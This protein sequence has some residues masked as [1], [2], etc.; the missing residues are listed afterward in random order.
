MRL[1][2]LMVKSLC[3]SI[4]LGAASAHLAAERHTPLGMSS[5]PIV[6]A[7]SVEI[8][9]GLAGFSLSGP[10]VQGGL[11]LGKASPGDQVYSDSTEVLVDADGNF[12]IG[13]DRDEPLQKKLVVVRNE[14]RHTLALDIARRTYEIQ[15][16]EGVAQKYVSPAPEQVARSRSD[17]QRVVE[18]RARLDTRLDFA[19]DFIWPV[20]GPIS[21][22]FGSQRGYNGVPKR[23]H[24]GVDIARETGTPVIAPAA[25]V[26]TMAEDLYYSGLTII[27]DHGHGLSSS[28][29]HLSSMAVEVGDVVEKG[30]TLGEVGATGRVTGPHLDWRM[31]WTGGSGN[32]RIDPALLV[33][34]MPGSDQ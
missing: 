30:E 24:Y 15:R 4:V 31:N 2:R 13:L 23:P 12:V 17:V 1:S 32:V 11:L 16:I 21:G 20:V 14:L 19:S 34:P 3:L 8:P 7:G 33:P 27:L 18:A 5:E 22:V 6:E 29:L 25:G 28:F 9:P 10:M 26:V